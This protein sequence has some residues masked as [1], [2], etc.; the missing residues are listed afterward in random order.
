[1]NGQARHGRARRMDAG[2][3]RMKIIA[4]ASMKGGSGKS[5]TALHLA[6]GLAR[7]GRRALLIDLD[8]QAN[9]TTWTQTPDPGA[10][11]LEMLAGARTLAALVAATATPGLSFCPASE[12]LIFAPEE[13][14]RTRTPDGQLA[15]RLA[16]YAAGGGAPA[17]VIVDTPPGF[18]ILTRN[19]LAAA[20]SV[21]IPTGT[22]F[23]SLS[24]LISFM[25]NMEKVRAHLNP[26]LKIGGIL[27]T[28][29]DR[30]TRHAGEV[31]DMVREHYGRDVFKTEIRENVR[32][33]EA[34][35][36]GQSVFDYAPDSHGA[37]DYAALCREVAART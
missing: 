17:F 2:K 36:F 9:L 23:L 13:L 4:V 25:G 1:M 8:P 33:A 18:G 16:D 28:R 37:E 30:R 12:A 24:G 6:A 7:A 21:I 26:A 34:V 11:P 15:A 29:V 20:G 35:S 32:L 5:T 31:A 19:A 22:H 3:D 27:L 14:A 10:A